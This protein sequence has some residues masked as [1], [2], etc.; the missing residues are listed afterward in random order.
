MENKV[1]L[2]ADVG[3]TNVRLQLS[4]GRQLIRSKTYPTSK[5]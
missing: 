2:V 1:M 5:H 4:T 3:G